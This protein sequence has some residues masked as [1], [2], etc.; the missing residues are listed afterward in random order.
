MADTLPDIRVTDA[1]SRDVVVQSSASIKSPMTEEDPG[2][3]GNKPLLNRT[4]H[5]QS[6]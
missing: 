1:Q 4:S 5:T 6:D 3:L 2:R